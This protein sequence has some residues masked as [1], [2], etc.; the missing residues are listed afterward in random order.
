MTAYVSIRPDADERIRV[1][2]SPC[3]GTAALP[4]YRKALAAAR[5]HNQQEHQKGNTMPDD[6]PDTELRTYELTYLDNTAWSSGTPR[7]K[8]IR[9]HAFVID[10]DGT[11]HGEVVFTREPRELVFLLDRQLLISVERL[12]VE[13]DKAVEA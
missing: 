8:T 9:A 6:Q 7:K 2:C 11:R 5:A 1:I 10:T 4:T 3:G 12:D 13:A